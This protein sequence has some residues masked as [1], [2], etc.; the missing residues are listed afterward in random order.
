MKEPTRVSQ[1]HRGV[2]QGR[3]LWKVSKLF[4]PTC[5][6]PTLPLYIRDKEKTK[7]DLKLINIQEM[8][9]GNS[10]GKGGYKSNKTK[11]IANL[12]LKYDI[13]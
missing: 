3:I 6:I 12:S 5:I 9:K 1:L 13:G 11:L 8:E 7:G 4:K 2:E 10:R